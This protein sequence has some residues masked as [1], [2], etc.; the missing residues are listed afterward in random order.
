MVSLDNVI[1]ELYC[2]IPS[3]IGGLLGGV[4]GGGEELY[5]ELGVRI[6]SLLAGHFVYFV[7]CIF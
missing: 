2:M 1:T 3:S 7:S 4:G 5:I 6:E